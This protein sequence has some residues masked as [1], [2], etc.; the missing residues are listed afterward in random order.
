MEIMVGFPV[1]RVIASL[2][3]GINFASIILNTC[4]MKYEQDNC[5]ADTVFGSIGQ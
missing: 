4:L 5:N 2:T 1:K 3:P